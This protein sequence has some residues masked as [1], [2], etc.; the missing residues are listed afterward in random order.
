MQYNSKLTVSKDFDYACGLLAK[1]IR[2][3]NFRQ[4][5][6]LKVLRNMNETWIYDKFITIA[7]KCFH[8]P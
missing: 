1:K 5:L 7:N 6:I 4:V 3:D 8:D 2:F